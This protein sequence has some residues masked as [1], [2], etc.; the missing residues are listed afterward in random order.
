MGLNYGISI[1]RIIEEEKK[2]LSDV[3]GYSALSLLVVQPVVG[4][5][6]RL[7]VTSPRENPCAWSERQPL[8]QFFWV[9]TFFS[10]SVVFQ[11]LLY[12]FTNF[13]SI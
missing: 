2:K 13:Y 9:S 4:M 5:T 10:V 12:L 11:H 7:Q 3:E 6:D 8:S 1:A